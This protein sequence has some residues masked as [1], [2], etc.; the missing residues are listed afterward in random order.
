MARV[1]IVQLSE[2]L[3]EVRF[4][5]DG[6]CGGL[7][8][9]MSPHE[10]RSLVDWYRSVCPRPGDPL[11]AATTARHGAVQV[12]VQGQTVYS[13]GFDGSSRPR[14]AGCHMSRDALGLLAAALA[15]HD[16]QTRPGPPVT[17]R[18]ERE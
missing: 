1:E 8:W 6:S 14:F 7:A 9:K 13:K 10:M 3:V 5:A 15:E 12:S 16:E 2:S 18:E 4:F 11:P 17:L